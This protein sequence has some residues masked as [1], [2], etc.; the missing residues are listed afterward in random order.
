M[1]PCWTQKNA[2]KSIWTIVFSLSFFGWNTYFRKAIT[3][4]ATRET[5][6]V[7][8]FAAL[9]MLASPNSV[10]CVDF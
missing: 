9:E 4:N 2:E 6:G 3:D 5:F 7:C 8:L 10:L 1:W